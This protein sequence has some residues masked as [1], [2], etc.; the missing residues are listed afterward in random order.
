MGEEVNRVVA[1]PIRC[2]GKKM[3]LILRATQEH[4]GFLFL[5]EHVRLK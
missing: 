5:S 1:L 4:V 3:P 2:H